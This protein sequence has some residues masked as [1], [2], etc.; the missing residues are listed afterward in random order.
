MTA[1]PRAPLLGVLVQDEALASHRIHAGYT[2]IIDP[3]AAVG[4]GDIVLARLADGTQVVAVLRVTPDRD[5]LEDDRGHVAERPPFRIVGRPVQVQ[6][7]P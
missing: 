6:F 2:L 5:W 1:H 4:S 7:E 3:Y